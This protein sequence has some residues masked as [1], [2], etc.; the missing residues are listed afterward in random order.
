MKIIVIA[1]GNAELKATWS[2]VPN[3]VVTEFRAL[4]HEV[5]CYDISCV[6]WIKPIRIIFNRVVRKI[7]RHWR[8]IPFEVTRMGVWMM[9]KWARNLVNS[10]ES[11][12]LV[13][14]FSFCID[15]KGFVPPTV[16]VHDWTNGYM[17]QM[18]H[19]RAM[20]QSEIKGDANQFAA[21][22]SAQKVVVLYPASAEYIRNNVG[23]NVFFYCN[24][25]NAAP[26][27]DLARN[28]DSGV[29]SKH[30][31]VIGGETYLENVRCVV[32]AAEKLGYND[33]VID[34]VGASLEQHGRRNV[35]IVSH[36]YL[37][38]DNPEQCK[39]YYELIRDA[40]CLVNI[41]TGWGGGSSIAEALYYG[42]PV[43]VGRYPDIIALYGQD[44]SFGFFCEPGNVN[45]LA[46]KLKLMFS[47]NE[48][49]YRRMCLCAAEKTCADTYTRFVQQIL[50]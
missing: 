7:W 5:V 46:S 27:I 17:Q 25:V 34:V 14:V 49:A 31:L 44:E 3:R 12:D 26:P 29:V 28:V 48:A 4:G 20:T 23:E 16:L 10:I 2:G 22:K 37:I 32:S 21:M 6:W 38:K 42:L 50:Q 47:L 11:V 43:I 9:S 41:R 39:K 33:L 1:N 30:I 13:V 19:G 24:P 45:E 36:G 8:W 35:K 18:F 15:S 40:R